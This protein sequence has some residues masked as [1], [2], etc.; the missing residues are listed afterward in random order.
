[1]MMNSLRKNSMALLLVFAANYLIACDHEDESSDT[2]KPAVTINDDGTTTN[3]AEYSAID[4]MTFYLDHIKYEVKDDYLEVTGFDKE[5][6]S[7]KAEI[8]SSI[9]FKGQNYPVT[10]IKELAFSNCQAMT[11]I[12]IPSGIKSIGEYAFLGCNTLTEVIIPPSVETIY[13]WA[14]A[15]CRNLKS[16]TLSEGLTTIQRGAFQGCTSLASV[17]IPSTVTNIDRE[18][19]YECPGLASIRVAKGNPIYDSRNDCNAIIQTSGNKLV[20]G[21]QSTTFPESVSSVGDGAFYGCFSLTSITIPS[22]IKTVGSQI[23]AGCSNLTSV[24]LS[25]GLTNISSGMFNRCSSLTNIIIPEGVINI[26]PHAFY[27]CTA[28]IS[29]AL[30]NTLITIGNEAFSDCTALT[31]ILLPD[32]LTSIGENAFYGCDGLTSVTLPSSLTSI[33]NR[34]F[35][36]YC[37]EIRSYIRNPSKCELTSESFVYAISRLYV[38]KGTTS[39]YETCE[40]WKEFF[41]ITEM[42]D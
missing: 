22:N 29:V 34:A 17:S 32:N 36:F 11:S 9:H 23:F 27:E 12:V 7:G 38:P 33:G 5:R 10:K 19:F 2:T 18:V 1:M 20:V 21:C 6:L 40:N 41:S 35:P 8:F 26:G 4:D 30:P 31:G 13:G 39:L 15:S 3:G 25:E 28:L 16:V 24:T 42:D 14:F 37:Q